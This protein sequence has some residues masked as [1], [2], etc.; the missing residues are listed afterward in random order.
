MKRELKNRG[1]STAGNKTDLTERLQA[2]L[3]GNF[4]FCSC[5]LIR[6]LKMKFL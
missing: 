2:A 6:K 4:T 1:K 3:I 5:E